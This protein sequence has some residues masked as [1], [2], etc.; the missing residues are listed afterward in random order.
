MPGDALPYATYDLQRANDDSHLK[1]LWILHYVWAGMMALFG[2]IPIIHV[3]IGILIVNGQFSSAAN[4]QNNMPPE[5][6]WLY[7][8]LGGLAILLGWTAA[9]LN[10][11]SAHGMRKRKWRLLSLIMSG[12]NCL[13]IPL[14]TTLGVFTFIVLLRSSVAMQYAQ[15]PARSNS[16]P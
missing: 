5:A 2:S 16:S 8:V 11:L 6:G 3:V 13:S 12:V 9:I 14:G 10:L 1:I 7:I 15:A 4:P